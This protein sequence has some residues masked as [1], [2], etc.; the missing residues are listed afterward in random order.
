MSS[1]NL[2]DQWNIGI[3]DTGVSPIESNTQA[4]NLLRF[5]LDDQAF[6]EDFL[7]TT[8]LR[9]FDTELTREGAK[10]ACELNSDH[11][12]L[13]AKAKKE[14]DEKLKEVQK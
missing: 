12:E 8:I 4:M 13:V 9:Y 6:T 5:L 11:K 10:I 2:I 14:F 7:I 3:Q 1:E